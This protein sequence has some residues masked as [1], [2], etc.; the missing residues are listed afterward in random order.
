LTPS[1]RHRVNACIALFAVWLNLALAQGHMHAVDVWG[2]LG[3]PVVTGTSETAFRADSREDPGLLA[4][5]HDC[6]ICLAMA[7]A[8]TGRPVAEFSLAAPGIGDEPVFLVGTAIEPRTRPFT[9]SLPR[10]PPV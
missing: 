3:H 6:A 9:P 8:G 10:A 5:D 1:P 4:A 7:I 2:P